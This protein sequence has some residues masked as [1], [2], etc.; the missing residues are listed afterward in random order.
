MAYQI[1]KSPH[2]R[3]EVTVTDDGRELTVN[4]D[5]DVH[6]IMTRYNGAVQKIREAEDE[7][8]KLR[9]GEG[10]NPDNIGEAYAALG[11]AI[12]NLFNL[13]FGEEQTNRIM[14]FYEGNSAEMLAD[15][16]PFLQDVVTPKIRD[17]QLQISRRYAAKPWAR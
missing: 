3:E 17:A 6:Q 9:E 12:M 14:E 10:L 15:F 16:V 13:L 1:Q 5:V 4:V 8:K 2:V 7:I 11:R